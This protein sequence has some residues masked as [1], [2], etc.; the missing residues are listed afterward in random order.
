MEVVEEGFFSR[1]NLQET[2]ALSAF[3]EGESLIIRNF[4]APIMVS[5]N[6]GLN[7]GMQMFW[8]IFFF[9]WEI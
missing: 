7:W 6:W 4:P 8:K 1:E 3:R 9:S 2:L 5:T